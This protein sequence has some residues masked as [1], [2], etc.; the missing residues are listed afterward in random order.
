MPRMDGTGPQG[1]EPGTGQASPARRA[2]GGRGGCAGK[3][4]ETIRAGR[5]LRPGRSRAAG[6]SR[7]GGRKQ[8]WR[9]IFGPNE[10]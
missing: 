5:G 1:K 10:D 9:A 4:T 7:R 2:G 8:G 6:S 3:E